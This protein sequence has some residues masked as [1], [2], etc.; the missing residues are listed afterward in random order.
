[1][2]P[3]LTGDKSGR[4]AVSASSFPVPSPSRNSR[5][6]DDGPPVSLIF[7]RETDLTFAPI[8]TALA[9]ASFLPD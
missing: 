6:P 5:F 4:D 1:M 7:T 8:R 2:Y 9:S 3:T